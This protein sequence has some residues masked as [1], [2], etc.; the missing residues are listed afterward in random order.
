MVKGENLI[1]GECT[2]SKLWLID[3]AGSER[4]AKTDVQGER[5]QEALF[6][7]KSLSALG[8]VISALAKKTRHIPFR[9]L[10]FSAFLKLVFNCSFHCWLYDCFFFK[11]Q[12]FEADTLA[13]RLTK[14]VSYFFTRMVE[15]FALF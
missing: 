13:S 12:E 11:F 7:N 8:D 3:L 1:H 10:N 6:I 2:N 15:S 5:L 14:Y 9:Y 4:V